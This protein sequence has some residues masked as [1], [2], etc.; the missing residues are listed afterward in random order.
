MKTE[1]LGTVSHELR[2]PLGSIK[3]YA[4]TLLTHG[5]RLKRD[6]LNFLVS[7]SFQLVEPL[8]WPV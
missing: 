2:T 6:F 5:Q 4:T 7:L 8:V 1:L 3:G